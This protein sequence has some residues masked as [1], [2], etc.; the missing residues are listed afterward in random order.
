VI[1]GL[2][3]WHVSGGNVPGA[4]MGWYAAMLH[5]RAAY[6]DPKELTDEKF[7][8]AVLKV[9]AKLKNAR[10]GKTG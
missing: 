9:K 7:D 10:E 8:Q 5:I 1:Y 6:G 4:G 2:R 3:N